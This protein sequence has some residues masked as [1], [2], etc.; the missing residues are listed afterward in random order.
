VTIATN[1]ATPPTV[2]PITAFWSTYAEYGK[3]TCAYTC[4]HWS[5]MFLCIHHKLETYKH[6]T[7]YGIQE[8]Y[9]VFVR[10]AISSS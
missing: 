4:T 10:Q 6:I 5:Q 3:D 1:P 7:G 9:Y 8:K 2:P